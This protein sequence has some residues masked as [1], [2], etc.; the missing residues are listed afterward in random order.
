MLDNDNHKEFLCWLR[1][2]IQN[3]Y[4]ES[5]P[6]IFRKLDYI[7]FN[8]VVVDQ[9]VPDS[10][11]DSICSRYFDTFHA[12]DISVLQDVFGDKFYSE[13][14]EQIRNFVIVMIGEIFKSSRKSPT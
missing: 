1:N 7:I 11:I 2:R 3:R 6:E 4:K 10:V 14:E 5:D 8:T 12:K 9:M 13:T